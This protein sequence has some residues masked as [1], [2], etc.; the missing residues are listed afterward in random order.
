MK[1]ILLFATVAAV[2]SMTACSRCDRFNNHETEETEKSAQDYVEEFSYLQEK[3]QEAVN[4]GDEAKAKELTEKAENLAREVEEK[5][6]NDPQFKKEFEKAVEEY[7][8][9]QK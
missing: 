2:L 6:D 4:A 1:K 5:C 8:E 3:Y 7:M 9:A